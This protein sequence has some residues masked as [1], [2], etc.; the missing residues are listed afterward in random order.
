MARVGGRVTVGRDAV[1]RY[2]V[3]AQGLDREPDVRHRVT[4]PDVL[5]LGVQDTGT[6]GALWALANRTVKGVVSSRLTAAVTEPYLRL[7]GSCDATHLYEM[8]FRLGTLHAGLELEPGTSPPVLRRVPRWPADH[9]HGVSHGEVAYPQRLDPVRGYLHHLGAARPADVAG[10]L[11]APLADVRARWPAD[12]AEVDVDG[13]PRWV[14][15]AD[16]DVLRSVS[17]SPA[18]GAGGP[19]IVRL[20]GPFDL[21]LQA[22]DRATL[23]ADPA[24]R[25]AL[26]PTLGRPGA[27]LVDGEILGTWRPRAAG[28]SLRLLVDRWASWDAGVEES[29]RVQAERLAEHRGVTLTAVS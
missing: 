16:L 25:K 8:P 9:L 23:V 29:I 6:G 21:F 15:E 26:W 27:V 3:H 10:Y 12:A 17:S 24:H 1:L 18:T 28:D 11:D 5:D 19:P 13:E 20:L 4:G 22:R 2:R 14:L 7:C